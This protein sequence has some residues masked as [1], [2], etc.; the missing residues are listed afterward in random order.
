MPV[1]LD[2]IRALLASVAGVTPGGM[3]VSRGIG[4][5]ATPSIL[6]GDRWNKLIAWGVANTGDAAL[7]AAAPDLHRELTEAVGEIERLRAHNA[8]M[9]AQ[10]VRIANVC[11]V[12]RIRLP[13][14]VMNRG[15][16]VSDALRRLAVGEVDD[17]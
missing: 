9:V 5:A 14:V 16:T 10:I 3:R 13:G 12:D 17:V 1:D 4:Q 7:F 6:G 8:R 11:H 15:E 2:K